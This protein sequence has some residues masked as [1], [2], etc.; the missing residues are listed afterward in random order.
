MP[1]RFLPHSDKHRGILCILIA[2]L[3]FS[4][5]TAFS[6]HMVADYSVA[7]TTFFRY[8][9]GLFPVLP[10]IALQGGLKVFPTRHF[11]GHFWRAATGTLCQFLYVY[12]ASRL[13]LAESISLAYTN[14]IFITL[15]SAFLL[16][17]PIG[18]GLWMAVLAGFSGVLLIAEPHG[19]SINPGA[20]AGVAGAMCQAVGTLGIYQLSR[21]DG[22]LST[23]AWFS[24]LAPLL[25]LPFALM[26][27]KMPTPSD[28]ILFA[29]LGCAGFCGQFFMTTAYKFGTPSF[30]GPFNYISILWAVLIGFVVWGDI[31]SLH[32]WLGTGIIV[33]AGFYIVHRERLLKRQP[34]AQP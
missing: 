1:R 18:P 8:F 7:Q 17:E 9:F 30:L 16:K 22:S 4:V 21:K 29:L 34:M 33:L 14:P 32:A 25:S 5:M 26:D 27:W 12:A 19:M 10:L 31:P 28:W 11:R 20:L 3:S 23:L 2:T 15:L 13:P 24:I 6:K